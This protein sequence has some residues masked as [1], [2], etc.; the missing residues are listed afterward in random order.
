MCVLVA[1][2]LVPFHGE[3]FHQFGDKSERTPH[4]VGPLITDASYR[5]LGSSGAFRTRRFREGCPV[6]RKEKRVKGAG[7]SLV[8][9][10]PPR[11]LD[12]TLPTTC[13]AE[14]RE[15]F[16]VDLTWRMLRLEVV[17]EDSKTRHTRLNKIKLSLS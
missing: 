6:S 16:C 1:A 11:Y 7:R 15:H 3:R 5:V 10:L 13:S 9:P 4:Y 14:T 12:A 8:D 2:W 17:S